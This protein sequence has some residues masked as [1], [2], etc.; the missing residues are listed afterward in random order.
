M[1]PATDSWQSFKYTTSTF[2]SSG[3]AS[4]SADAARMPSSV[5]CFRRS[6]SAFRRSAAA[7][8]LSSPVSSNIE[9]PSFALSRRPPAFK[10][11]PI[12]KPIW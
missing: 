10:Q 7:S 5:I 11:G 2:G 9:S 8:A 4:I 1:M 12:T 6:F 3:S